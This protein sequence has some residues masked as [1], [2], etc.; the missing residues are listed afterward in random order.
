MK[1]LFSLTNIKYIVVKKIFCLLLL[2]TTISIIQL[3]SVNAQETKVKGV[4]KDSITGEVIPM[5]SVLFVGTTRGITSDFDGEF[6]LETRE[7]VSEVLIAY[8]GYEKKIV[9]IKFGAFN[10]LDVKLAPNTELNEITV[11]PGVNPAIALM[12]KVYKNKDKNDISKM[13][14]YQYSTYTKMEID[15]TNINPRFKNKKLQKNFG[16]IFNYMDTSAITGKAFL[17]VM[18]TESQS[19]YYYRKSPR[20]EKEIVKASRISGVKDNKTFSQFTGHFYVNIN[21]YDNYV[22]IFEVNFVSPLNNYGTMF[23]DYF[24][25]DSVNV[26]NRKIYKLRFHPKAYSVPVLDGQIMIDS[27]SLALVSA[28][29]TKPKRTDVNWLRNLVYEVENKLCSDCS[30]GADA[31]WFPLNTKFFAD[32]SIQPRDSS[33]LTSFLGHRQVHY[34]NVRITDEIPNDIEKQKTSISISKNVNQNSEEY[35]SKNRPYELTET[36]KQIY[37]VVD[38]IKNVPLYKNIYDIVNTALFGYFKYNS[39][40]LGP[41]YKL[42]S[43]NDIEGNRF[44]FGAKTNSDFDD[45]IQFRGYLAYGTKDTRFKGSVGMTYVFNHSKI[46]RLNVDFKHDM[47][48]LGA[49]VNAFSEGNILS[50]ILSKGD[51]KSLSL[52]NQLDIDWEEEWTPGFRNTIGI[53]KRKISNSPYVRFIKPN[54]DEISSIHSTIFKLNTRWFKDEI[55][56]R[57]TFSEISMGSDY[58]MFELNLSAGLKNMFENDYEFYRT[59]M[60]ISHDFDIPP[61]GYSAFKFVVGKIFGKVP[62][63][64]LKL[65][66]GNATYFYDPYAFSCMEF[67]EFA[68]D[69]WASLFWEHHFKGFLLGKIP[70]MKRLKWRS[71][72]TFKGLIGKL[73]DKNNGSLENTNA[74]LKF[75]EGMKSVSKP[76]F[77]V[78]VGVEN[79]FKIIRLDG[80]WRLSHRDDNSDVSNFALNISIHLSF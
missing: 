26:D 75:P 65:H 49:S 24:L 30:Q 64:L 78:G 68:S 39:L 72:A 51:S 33:K 60:S 21:L 69:S 40:S 32:F 56:V 52:V 25:V 53:Q 46:S 59:E 61:F 58:P 45:K 71:V 23:Y 3:Q 28:R 47:I 36:E 79:I 66:E 5:A 27:S 8:V 12:K 41:Y 76:Y 7:K 6:Y 63:P 62:Y 19:D 17:P 2:V 55:L 11:N 22:N 77:E 31:R 67:Y 34:S 70:L 16:F 74:Y 44:Q 10:Q 14:G 18:I 13:D 9:K 54:G 15:V 43:Y 80:V 73:S 57:N 48:Q 42:Y 50:T 4:V 38:S 29:V 20:F 1:V 35:W 37:T